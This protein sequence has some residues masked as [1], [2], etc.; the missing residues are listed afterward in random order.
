MDLRT[1]CRQTL[2]EDLHPWAFQVFFPSVDT[3]KPLR[4]TLKGTVS[5]DFSLQ[6]FSLDNSNWGPDKL[7]NIFSNLVFFQIRRV[8]RI[9]KFDLP[10]FNIAGCLKQFGDREVFKH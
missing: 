4:P 9:L 1:F 2:T 8:I 10:L 7:P 3:H 5:R 6:F